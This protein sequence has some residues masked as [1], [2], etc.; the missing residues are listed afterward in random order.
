MSDTLT[1][2]Q[3][4]KNENIGGLYTPDNSDID[5]LIAIVNDQHVAR[6]A[7]LEAEN[8]QLESDYEKEFNVSE[9]LRCAREDLVARTAELESDLKFALSMAN[10]T[11]VTKAEVSRMNKLLEQSK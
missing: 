6:I 11:S 7:E 1:K 3:Q 9:D 2:I 4:W 5:E 8:K 10:K